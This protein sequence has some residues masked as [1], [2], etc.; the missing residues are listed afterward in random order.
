[1]SAS[2]KNAKDSNGE[3]RTEDGG[4]RT[5]IRYQKSVFVSDFLPS[6]S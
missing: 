4:R 6:D 1:L 3:Q 5:E 2:V